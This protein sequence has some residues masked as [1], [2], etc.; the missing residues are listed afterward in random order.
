ML[1]RV[2][3]EQ[4]AVECCVPVPVVGERVSWQLSFGVGDVGPASTTVVWADVQRYV[5]GPHEAPPFFEGW[6]LRA[7]DLAAWSPSEVAAGVPVR[8]SLWHEAHGQ[9]PGDQQVTAGEVR[10]VQVVHQTSR[11]VGERETSALPGAYRLCDAPPDH[12]PAWVDAPQGEPFTCE[13]GLLVT[14]ETV[15]R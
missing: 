3:I 2:E 10:R 7:G 15:P 4:W 8:G 13:A 11:W 14:L 1:V 6:T 9:V 12:R 5:P